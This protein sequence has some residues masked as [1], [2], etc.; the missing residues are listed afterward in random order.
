MRYDPREWLRPITAGSEDSQSVMGWDFFKDVVSPA[1]RGVGAIPQGSEITG[2]Q[3]AKPIEDA[4]HWVDQAGQTVGKAVSSIPIIGQPM[5]DILNINTTVFRIGLSVTEGKSVDKAVVD[6]LKSTIQSVKE[7]APIA[8]AIISLVPGIG[9]LASAAIAAGLA[10]AEGHS[11]DQVLES[12]IAGAIPGGTLAVD[13]FKVGQQALEG[14]VRD[15][16]SFAN[17]ALDVAADAVGIQIPDAAKKVIGAGLSMTQSLANGQKPDQAI[18][19]AALPA[20]GPVVGNQV[21][22]LLGQGKLQEA[23][24]AVTSAIPNQVKQLPKPQVD[25]IMRGLGVGAA[26]GHAKT[27][28]SSKQAQI[29]KKLQSLRVPMLPMTAEERSLGARLP[30][31]EQSGFAIGVNVK[32][33]KASTAD[34]SIIR[35]TLK[36]AREQDGFDA[37]IAMHIAQVSDKKLPPHI[38][39]A[40]PEVRA[41]YL[42]HRG[43]RSA[44]PAHTEHVVSALPPQAMTG[45]EAS[46]RES[47]SQWSEIVAGGLVGGFAGL[48]IGGPVAAVAGAIASGLGIR[49][50]L[51]K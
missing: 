16:A 18:I 34:I 1:A 9:P 49:Y 17:T 26:I 3:P 11:V 12:A 10:I 2:V 13:A 22:S 21:K 44:T 27:L 45:V 50:L 31:D 42:V 36:S 46:Q 25:S 5:N 4:A 41:G 6:N 7:V 19:S 35:R 14:K 37:A 20:L 32:H 30:A 43:M 39:D 24:D 40:R 23:A 29:G 51:H 15:F 33:M 8:Q 47:L 48:K 38:A 28:Q